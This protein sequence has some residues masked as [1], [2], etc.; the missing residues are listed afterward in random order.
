VSDDAIHLVSYNE[1]WP[2]VAAIEIAAIRAILPTV[3][4]EIEH[5]GSTAI[6]GLSA[7]PIIDLLIGVD[8]LGT[9][10][11]FIEPLERMG[12][13]YWRENPKAEHFYFV[14][15]LPL[16]GGTGRTHHIH[17]YQKDHEEIKK[18]LLFRDYLRTHPE[19]SQVYS[20]LKED[21]A[22]KFSNDREAYT[23]AKTNFVN[24]ILK[25]A[26][27]EP[28]SEHLNAAQ[29]YWEL[30]K[31]PIFHRYLANHIYFT[32]SFSGDLVLRLTPADHR[33]K[34]E[35]VAEI[36]FMDYLARKDFPLAIPVLSKN[37][38]LVEEISFGNN[39]FFATAFKKIEGARATDEESLEP[40]FLFKWG[41]YLAQ[42]HVHSIVFENTEASQHRRPEWEFD[43]VKVKAVSFSKSSSSM[44]STRLQECVDWLSRLDKKNE[45]YGLI[46]GDLH[47]GNFFVVDG[48]IVSFDYDDSCYHW[49]LYDIAACLSTVLKIA[50]NESDRQQIIAT[51]FKGYESVRPVSQQW[52]NRFEY[53]YQYRL[54]LVFNW[55][56]AMISEGRFSSH[57]IEN[58]KSVEPWYLENMKRQIDFS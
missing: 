44:A 50:K 20:Q 18:R 14:K 13:S 29:S 19:S 31:F 52:R 12:Y 41:A 38:L 42:L 30:T 40:N 24:S 32:A 22:N 51:F 26:E 53:F 36:S 34:S 25:L 9:A 16:V 48:Q 21:L 58:W 54:A 45:N 4:F 43:A 17:L 6:P 35:V 56:N 1:K 57:T 15:G 28:S 47:L 39:I 11:Q 46:H 23:S 49:F 7:K 10:K 37:G 2:D 27:Q 55:M 3:E 33:T 8:S 5:I